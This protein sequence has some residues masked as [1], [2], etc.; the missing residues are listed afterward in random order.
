[1]EGRLI[2]SIP[3]NAANVSFGVTT[4]NLSRQ[5]HPELCE[6]ELLIQLKCEDRI[7]TVH[8][9]KLGST[10][11][12]TWSDL[13][14]DLTEHAWAKRIEFAVASSRGNADTATQVYA[15]V[16]EPVV[17]VREE[18][19]PPNVIL[20]VIDT[21]RRNHLGCY[22]YDRNTSPNIDGFAQRGVFFESAYAQD[23]WTK[24]SIATM[25]TS[26][27]PKDHG[28]VGVEDRLSSELTTLPELLRDAGYYTVAFVAAGAVGIPGLNF[29]QGFD[30]FVAMT[31]DHHDSLTSV[32]EVM[33]RLFPWIKRNRDKSFFLY[34]H[35]MDPHSPYFPVPPYD[36][37][38]D[39][40]YEGRMT[41][42][43]RGPGGYQSCRNERDIAH[44]KALYDGEIAY[45]DE[46]FGHFV[47][48]LRELGLFQNTM[49]VFTSDHGEE[50]NDRGAWG[51]G[52]TL[53]EELIKIPL[54]TKFPHGEYDGRRVLA[55]VRHLDLA[56][57]ILEAA[58]LP[59]PVEMEGKSL[60]PI[61]EDKKVHLCDEVFS[62][63]C[64]NQ[65]I[66]YSVISDG[67]KYILRTKPHTSRELYDLRE[68]PYEIRNLFEQDSSSANKLA[69]RLLDYVASSERVSHI[70]FSSTESASWN[71]S[72]VVEGVLARVY[73]LSPDE[74]ES[75]SID[76]SG[77]TL[78]FELRTHQ[79][80][81][82]FDF[83]TVPP[84]AQLSIEIFVNDKRLDPSR[85]LLGLERRGATANPYD[86]QLLRD[87]TVLY[88][89]DSETIEP[90]PSSEATCIFWRTIPGAPPISTKATFD[91]RTR[92]K[93]KALGYIE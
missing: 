42:A 20:Y 25:L 92:D 19:P 41:G 1:M 74:H 5:F 17:T 83:V 51:H 33:S 66:L 49:F 9:L 61:L 32:A 58:G 37:M 81:E 79:S 40:E 45:S 38:F 77:T 47:S 78:S 12:C 89:A 22:G 55:E 72:I 82:G 34:V 28:A 85:L 6:S 3:K 30:Q 71:G 64:L 62:E 68:D 21:L 87:Q 8:S 57:T 23:S 46:Y 70:R 60:L 39:P 31:E 86:T 35:L 14:L 2:F 80:I 4:S 11:Q 90:V 29:E 63:E 10:I 88:A 7:E 69:R 73:P 84:D 27:Y 48:E 44:V 36:T 16:S 53:Y 59:I 43:R 56:P 76:S 93:L 24:P 15:A 13:Q 91:R 65:N 18:K 54:I 50:L 26:R 67:Q 52:H 75:L